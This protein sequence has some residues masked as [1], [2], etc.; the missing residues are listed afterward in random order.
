VGSEMC[1]R[2]SPYTGIMVGPRAMHNIHAFNQTITIAV[3]SFEF[4]VH[5]H[6]E[7]EPKGI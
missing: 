2:D 1:I 3:T 4:S 7:M 6:Q 5:V